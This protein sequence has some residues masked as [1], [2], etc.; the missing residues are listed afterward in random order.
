[1][2]DKNL[3]PEIVS[4]DVGGYI[5]GPSAPLCA[6]CG[7]PKA[8]D[9]NDWCSECEE[10]EG[11]EALAVLRESAVRASF[12]L[13]RATDAAKDALAVPAATA[14]QLRHALVTLVKAVESAL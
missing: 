8:D 11:A 5:S 13:E 3:R 9:G 10:A 6:R 14:G 12:A 4:Y 2:T 1:M 7:Q